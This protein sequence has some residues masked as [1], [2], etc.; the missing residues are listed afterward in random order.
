MIFMQRRIGMAESSATTVSEKTPR[1]LAN[2]DLLRAISMFA[3]VVVHMSGY[4]GPIGGV[5]TNAIGVFAIVCDPVFFA[6]SGYFALRPLKTGLFKYYVRKFSSIVLPLFLYSVLLYVYYSWSSGLSLFG[7][8]E[9][10]SNVLS[11]WWF[12]P[13]LIP[14]LIAA[15]FLYKCLESLSDDWVKLLIKL[16][17]VLSIWGIAG[18]FLTWVF[19]ATGHATLGRMVGI[20]TSLLPATMVPNSYFIYFCLGFFI[21]RLI[22]I[23]SDKRKNQLIVLGLL[24]WIL[25][26]AFAHFGINRVDP[27][28]AWLPATIV[29]FLIVDRLSIPDGIASRC[30]GWAAKRSYSIY[31]LQYTT[32]EIAT[33]AVYTSFFA[34]GIMGHIALVRL[35]VWLGTT[36]LAYA[37]AFGFASIAD[38]ALLRP[39]QGF[40]ESFLL[41]MQKCE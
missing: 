13:A 22:P 3:V 10:F 1:R 26:T 17:V 30:I 38:S 27:S 23:L 16:S 18:C 25:D 19:E 7:Y 21:R 35:C 2:W 24:C 15:P 34:G 20:C 33:A 29:I 8:I 12:I 14:F 11:P 41:R 5:P 36:F 9:Y 32:I 40:V 28:Y 39:L 37:L 4:L 31:L 6:L